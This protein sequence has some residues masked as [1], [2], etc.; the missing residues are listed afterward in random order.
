MFKIQLKKT[1][2]NSYLLILFKN[3]QPY[4]DFKPIGFI[5]NVLRIRRR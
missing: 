5:A 4:F 1:A 2:T 3:R